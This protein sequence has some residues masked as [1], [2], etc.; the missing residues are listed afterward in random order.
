MSIIFALILLFAGALSGSA[1]EQ[2]SHS[3]VGQKGGQ[4]MPVAVDGVIMGQWTM[5]LE[6]ARKLAKD[7]GL[8]ILLMFTGSDWC[9][10]CVMLEENVFTT[11]L[12]QTYVRDQLIPVYIDM[13]KDPRLVPE[14][15]RDRN[16]QLQSKFNIKGPPLFVLLDSDGSS[17]ISAFG[18]RGDFEAT[19]FIK[20]V[21]EALRKGPAA[22]KR[23]ASELTKQKA[24]RY[25]QDSQA[26]LEAQRDFDRWLA[27]QPA[28]SAENRE[29]YHGHTTAVMEAST[30]V[31]AMEIESSAS[32][33]LP[34]GQDQVLA[35][36]K[37]SQ[38]HIALLRDLETHQRG[39]E[40]WL[41]GLPSPTDEHRAETQRRVTQL[42]ESLARVAAARVR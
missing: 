32:A 28:K 16:R 33:L 20:L 12:W 3:E 30:R 14:K 8:P 35:D 10:Y 40:N 29:R 24:E 6:A 18:M 9:R 26:L 39:L 19:N 4:G 11:P 7:E 36:L 38:S 23:I 41:L 21:G 17:D 13:P 34:N 31:E 27:T 22:S 1:A 25:R 37:L 2:D 42:R 5:D 15:Y